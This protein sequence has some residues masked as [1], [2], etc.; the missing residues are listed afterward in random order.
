MLVRFQTRIMKDTASLSVE[1]E[2]LHYL[3]DLLTN[4]AAFVGIM[5]VMFADFSRADP[6]IAALI[7]FYM[8]Y[9]TIA[10]FQKS[11]AV[12]I[13][14]EINDDLKSEIFDIVKSHNK[15]LGFHDVR[16]RQSGSSKGKFF[17]Q[18][19][20]EVSEHVSLEESHNIADQVEE[21]I[22]NKFPDAEIILHVDP[23]NVIEEKEFVDA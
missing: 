23:S 18:M 13:D 9:T 1:S 16:T 12:L 11:I 14:R 19:H 2:K 22:L 15:V 8:I 20:I 5:L 10:I 6:L 21:N 7:A 4:I 3:S 17:M